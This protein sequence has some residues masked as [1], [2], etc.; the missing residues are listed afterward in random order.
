MEIGLILLEVFT[1]AVVVFG[2]LAIFMLRRGSQSHEAGLPGL[3]LRFS[4]LLFVCLVIAVVEGVLLRPY[5][6]V[7]LV[8]VGAVTVYLIA[9][10]GPKFLKW[11]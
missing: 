4:V 3:W 10:A 1:V 6:F 9:K 5:S 7:W 11:E 2:A 8:L